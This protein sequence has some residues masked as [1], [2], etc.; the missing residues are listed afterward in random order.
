MIKTPPPRPPNPAF[1][2]NEDDRQIIHD[3]FLSFARTD[4]HSDQ[5]DAEPCLLVDDLRD[6][7][8][9]IGDRPSEEALGRLLE[10]VDTD[11]S[12]TI[13]FGEFVAGC[14]EILGV[15]GSEVDVDALVATFRAIDR[16]GSGDLTLDE[17]ASLLT[18][19]GGS[20]SQDNID[21]I[22]AAADANGDGAIDLAEFLTLMTDP[23]H[24]NLSWR[25]RAGF[26][27][28]LVMGGPG[29]GK[30][31]LCGR[32]VDRC[33]VDHF[34]SGDMLRKEVES[35]SGLAGSIQQIMQEGRLVP[36][37]TIIALLKKQLRRFAGS[38]VALDGFPRSVDN[39][40]DFERMCGRPEFAMLVD[41]PD[42]VM[43]ERMLRRG[44]TSGRADDNAE[45]AAKRLRTYR[46]QTEPTIKH[47]TASGV[48][49]YRLDGRRSPEEVWAD[50]V[51]KSATIR[52]LATSSNPK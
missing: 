22:M 15:G 6:L 23:A 36:S 5:P 40:R 3:L 38:R 49:L 32:L 52:S 50:L 7:L 37:S 20:L 41:V 42:E 25:L 16:D 31:T 46:K 34:S 27:V 12:G 47:L 44:E 2:R 21:A 9:S 33:G 35:G 30:G 48:P 1:I 11:N 18:T 51:G 8:L 39:Y 4:Y 28:S 26:R 17:L 10:K 19:T 29:S 43:M 13:E 24:T 45:T 14:E